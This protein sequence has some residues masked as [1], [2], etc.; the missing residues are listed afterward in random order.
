MI[1]GLEKALEELSLEKA[2]AL[3]AFKAL[4]KPSKKDP[5]F[6]FFPLNK[7]E[8]T[9]LILA[10]KVVFN[11]KP[12]GNQIFFM[13][14][15]FS[16]ESSCVKGCELLTL[17][18]A[19]V[20]YTTL[21]HR[22]L[23]QGISKEKDAFAF[24]NTLFYQKGAFL[25][26]PPQKK[27]TVDIIYHSTCNASFFPRLHIVLGK[28]AH[29]KITKKFTGENFCTPNIYE[30]LYCSLEESSHLY[31]HQEKDLFSHHFFSSARIFQKKE[32]YFENVI[33]EPRSA[34]MRLDF[35]VSLLEEKAKCSLM[36]AFHLKN[37]QEVHTHI[38]V[39]HQAEETTSNQLFKAVLED[40]SKQSFD[41]KIFVEK[42]AQ[43]TE[44]Y[45]LNN[46]LLLSDHARCYSQPNLEILADDVKASHGATCGQIDKDALFFM[47]TRGISE[48]EARQMLI[49]GFLDEV[50]NSACSKT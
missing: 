45:Q 12:C 1:K 13:E 18:E 8:K 27:V 38:K 40:F 26:V 44:A 23:E 19:E 2:K 48:Y 3:K 32:S 10:E 24:L 15:D 17:E 39:T 25:Y 50:K 4:E 46:T 5:R 29:L 34:L 33:L 7:V 49:S 20:V 30:Y 35:Q 36:G 16:E 28:G 47:K 22:Q 41:G 42:Q 31:I 43:K 21:V 37:T 11:Q 14:G 9:D 6:R